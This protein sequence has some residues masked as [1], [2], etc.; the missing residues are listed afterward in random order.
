MAFIP[1]REKRSL[2]VPCIHPPSWKGP[3]MGVR[4]LRGSQQGLLNETSVACSGLIWG[5][6]RL[7]S[8]ASTALSAT[9]WRAVCQPRG[10]QGSLYGGREAG[11]ARRGTLV[12][13]SGDNAEDPKVALRQ[14][15]GKPRAEGS[16]LS[17]WPGK[18]RQDDAE[19]SSYPG[20]GPQALRTGGR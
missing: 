11:K 15:G 3:E 2:G 1:P 14:A 6:G 19:R 17:P 18:N 10:W 7:V 8:R 9:W 16:L 20:A 12:H 5:T 13:A 4:R